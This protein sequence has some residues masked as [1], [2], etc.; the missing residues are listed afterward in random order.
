MSL[1][2]RLALLQW[3][4]QADAWILE[5]DYDSEYRFAS[6]PLAALQGL[7]S[8]G[9]VI[10]LGA[11]SKVLFPALRLGHLVVPMN[12]APAFAAARAIA[13]LSSPSIEQAVLADFIAEGHFARHIRRM[14]T[15]YAERQGALVEAASRKLTGLLEV[16]PTETGLHLVGWLPEGMDD[17]MASQRAAIHGVETRALSLYRMEPSCRGG[18]VLGYAAF[19]PTEIRAGIGKLAT[20]LR[21]VVADS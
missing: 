19:T 13:G 2:R 14:R 4:S 8:E 3:A 10:Y 5:D 7:D 20:A 6:R 18:L 1:P 15:L 12:L 17:R 11:F 21:T 16:S 9:R